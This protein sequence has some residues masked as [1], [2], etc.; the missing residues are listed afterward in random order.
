MATKKATE[1]KI[2]KTI[3]TKRIG[4]KIQPRSFESAE[5]MIETQDEI[6]WSTIEER[7]EGLANLTKLAIAD[8]DETYAE[9][10]RVLGIEEKK[11][12]I[13]SDRPRPSEEA[14]TEKTAEKVEAKKTSKT[15][16]TDDDD[17]DLFDEL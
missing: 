1:K 16:K 10:S 6:E 8:F 15:A 17:F 14:E 11:A 3:A 4:R 2:N 12:F 7:E 9:V 5:I 13:K